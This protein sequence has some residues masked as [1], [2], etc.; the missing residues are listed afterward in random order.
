[1]F[2]FCPSLFFNGIFNSY[3]IKND[4]VV[5]FL[6]GLETGSVQ[7]IKFSSFAGLDYVGPTSY[8]RR[9]SLITHRQN[10]NER[11]CLNKTSAIYHVLVLEKSQTT[12]FNDNNSQKVTV[13][14]QYSTFELRKALENEQNY[15]IKS[16]LFPKFNRD[17]AIHLSD[18]V[19]WIENHRAERE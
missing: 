11:N 15:S 12:K 6:A 1:M 2:F 5:T 17:N 4:G 7:F 8:F 9:L 16:Q 10:E 19:N 3:I 18:V 14:F 13:R